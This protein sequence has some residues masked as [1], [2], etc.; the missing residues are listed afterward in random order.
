M[1]NN[2]E[3]KV[4]GEIPI[5]FSYEVAPLIMDILAYPNCRY[6]LWETEGHN[7]LN[8]ATILT[9]EK[10][11]RQADYDKTL[12]NHFADISISGENAGEY[13]RN[14]T[15][16]STKPWRLRLELRHRALPYSR[17]VKINYM[18]TISL[19]AWE[20]RSWV[21]PVD[22]SSGDG[23]WMHASRS[24][25]INPHRIQVPKYAKPQLEGMSVM[26]N[27]DLQKYGRVLKPVEVEVFSRSP[28]NT[29][30]STVFLDDDNRLTAMFNGPHGIETRRA[31]RVEYIAY[32]QAEALHWG[33][34]D[35]SLLDSYR[36]S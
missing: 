14:P 23:L 7:R 28:D 30:R 29:S 34:V 13:W 2:P 9:A 18:D 10:P 5:I 11:L 25:E 21:G 3:T 12:E 31:N 20:K 22:S 36:V 4:V 35:Q 19:P 6:H 27:P 26:N 17:E 33:E 32:R 8:L 1:K 24:W 16:D 15:F